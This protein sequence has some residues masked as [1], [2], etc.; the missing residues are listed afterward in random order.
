MRL[1][2]CL[3]NTLDANNGDKGLLLS[4]TKG[5]NELQIIISLFHIVIS[6]FC[7]SRLLSSQYEFACVDRLTQLYFQISFL[8]IIQLYYY[9]ITSK[10]EKRQREAL[11]IRKKIKVITY[12][13]PSILY[14]VSIRQNYF[15]LFLSNKIM[16]LRVERIFI[17]L[18]EN[19][20][21]SYSALTLSSASHIT[22]GKRLIALLL[23][24][25]VLKKPPDTTMSGESF[26]N[27]PH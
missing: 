18:P 13:L 5:S 2:T 3:S 8:L 9:F 25:R 1:I 4:P 10:K 16:H 24:R 12:S 17:H 27:Q 7:S 11:K 19:H 6:L 20:K 22:R 23:V 15:F 14:S 21:F 26:E